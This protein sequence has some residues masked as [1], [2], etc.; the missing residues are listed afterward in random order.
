MK[1]FILILSLALA[2]FGFVQAQSMFENNG[3]VTFE[4]E[5]APKAHWEAEK[6]NF[7][8]IPQGTPV[9]HRFEFT[10]TGNAPLE[11]S[12][13]KA[14][15]GCTATNYSK[16]PVAPGEM[17][18]VEAQ[19]NAAG[20]GIFSKTVTVRTNAAEGVTVLRFQGEVVKSEQ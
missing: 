17:G 15:C 16:E 19:Y 4:Q 9:T 1:K 12:S 13:V 14:S 20:V 2:S 11:I 5:G 8:Q 18:F 6:H 3:A 10:N 7:G